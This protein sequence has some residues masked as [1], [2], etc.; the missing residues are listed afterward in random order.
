MTCRA[1]YA[2]LKKEIDAIRLLQATRSNMCA[3]LDDNDRNRFSNI[4]LPTGQCATELKSAIHTFQLERCALVPPQNPCCDNPI[5]PAP[6]TA[7]RCA[8]PMD[9]QTPMGKLLPAFKQRERIFCPVAEDVPVASEEEV[10]GEPPQHQTITLLDCARDD[11][12]ERNASCPADAKDMEARIGNNLCTILGKTAPLEGRFT[13]RFDAQAVLRSMADSASDLC[14]FGVNAF[15]GCLV[16]SPSLGREVEGRAFPAA[17]IY[18]RL[19]DEDDETRAA[20]VADGA[21]PV[22]PS[23]VSVSVLAEF[24][25]AADAEGIRLLHF[26][27]ANGKTPVEIAITPSSRSLLVSHS[28][29][30]PDA[31]SRAEAQVVELRRIVLASWPDLPPDESTFPVAATSLSRSDSL[32]DPSL[33]QTDCAVGA[34]DGALCWTLT[35]AKDPSVDNLGGE[36]LETWRPWS[37]LPSV[38]ADASEALAGAVLREQQKLSETGFVV[39]YRPARPDGVPEAALITDGAEFVVVSGGVGTSV[40]DGKDRDWLLQRGFYADAAAGG[41]ALQWWLDWYPLKGEDP[42]ATG[43]SCWQASPSGRAELYC[44]IFGRSLPGDPALVMPLAPSALALAGKVGQASHAGLF[45]LIARRTHPAGR[46]VSDYQTEPPVLVLKDAS[47]ALSFVSDASAD[48]VFAVECPEEDGATCEYGETFRAALFDAHRTGIPSLVVRSRD[49]GKPPNPVAVAECRGG[50]ETLVLGDLGA[51]EWSPE[52]R[53][54]EGI[55]FLAQKRNPEKWA[56]RE[57]APDL[58]RCLTSF[59]GEPCATWT[60]SGDLGTLLTDSQELRD[61]RDK[62]SGNLAACGR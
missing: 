48:T 8:L 37:L 12:A 14:R 51:G 59:S 28:V 34:G 39:A 50:E 61:N 40:P 42:F 3:P 27:V 2:V 62:L 43:R 17:A 7:S 41:A 20:L 45:D 47:G 54:L 49:S 26:P 31:P 5:P 11:R 46:I 25:S 16:E 1:E 58:L 23:L 55:R 4:A 52:W 53:S 44:G 21:A 24:S 22:A 56:D 6:D 30:A 29:C 35:I 9:G 19:H 13:G 32:G 33:K 57:S 15:G 38:E 18:T 60:R 10:E 36:R